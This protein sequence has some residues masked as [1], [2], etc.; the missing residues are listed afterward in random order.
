MKKTAVVMAALM[1]GATVASAQ[2]TYTMG[3]NMMPAAAMAQGGEEPGQSGRPKDDLFAGTEVFEKN[4]TEVSD[5]NMGPDMLGMVSGHQAPKAHSMLLNTVRTYE[6]D[7]PGLYNMAE[8]EKFRQKLNSGD[9]HCSV[10][11]KNLKTGES[12]DV[13]QKDRTDGYRE[14]AIITVEKKELTFIHRIERVGEGGHSDASFIVMPGGSEK[15]MTMAMVGNAKMQG[16]MAEMQA[17]LATMNGSM[18]VLPESGT[19]LFIAPSGTHTMTL[20]SL[21]RFPAGPSGKTTM[22]S[23]DSKA[24]VAAVGAAPTAAPSPVAP[25]LP[26]AA[27][28]PITPQQ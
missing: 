14:S 27:P 18:M 20:K 19:S 12:T 16:K 13:C 3:R 28:A 25:P 9:W 6:Y 11:T 23:E 26:A 24:P 21:H 1:M 10:H 17:H 7:Q 5:I 15:S 4:A 22:N 2:G 8:V